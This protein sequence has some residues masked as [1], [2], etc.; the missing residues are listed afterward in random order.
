[1]V[2]GQIASI[3]AFATLSV[4]TAYAGPFDM[5]DPQIFARAED[6]ERARLISKPCAETD[7]GHGC[8]RYDGRALRESPCLYHIDT[9][10]IRSLPTDQCFKMDTSRRYRGVWVDEFEGQR[11][12]PEGTTVPTWPRTNPSSPGW[13]EQAEQARLASI[14]LDSSNIKMDGKFRQRGAR[15]FIEF[16]G[17]KTTYPGAYGHFGMSGQEII[18]DRVISMRE[19]P[20][21]D[22]CK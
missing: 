7:V 9:R 13:R 6:Q 11:F 5:P 10:T 8:Y 1:M 16:E 19:C 18:V 12:I 14:W 21:E 20:A 15:R 17:R 3:L 2:K 4:V 22:I